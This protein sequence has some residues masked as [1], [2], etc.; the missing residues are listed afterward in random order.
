VEDDVLAEFTETKIPRLDSACLVAGWSLSRHPNMQRALR[1]VKDSTRA[2]GK[3]PPFDLKPIYRDNT[4]L[5][6]DEWEEDARQLMRTWLEQVHAALLVVRGHSM[7]RMRRDVQRLF[8]G[9]QAENLQR[10]ASLARERLEHWEESLRFLLD[11]P[12]MGDEWLPSIPLEAA[13]AES[14][15]PV[16]VAE[17]TR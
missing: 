2:L 17:L 3:I 11:E 7:E 5:A 16:D 6:P 10:A 9:R 4:A 12:P 1:I 14:P 15:E 13:P 8:P